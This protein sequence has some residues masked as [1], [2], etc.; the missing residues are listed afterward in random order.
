MAPLKTVSVPGTTDWCIQK[1]YERLAAMN[2]KA[3]LI[4]LQHFALVTHL[5]KCL[6]IRNNCLDHFVVQ[7]DEI[8]LNLDH[9]DFKGS[10]KYCNSFH[11]LYILNGGCEH[12][13]M[14]YKRIWE[15]YFSM[16]RGTIQC[17]L[18]L[19]SEFIEEY[20]CSSQLSCSSSPA[21]QYIHTEWWLVMCTCSSIE[22]SNGTTTS[23]LHEVFC[24]FLSTS[25]FK[26]KH[27]MHSPC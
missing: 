10:Y 24:T 17:E 3:G 20:C 25:L 6:G 11:C 27:F 13:C 8:L 12:H 16:E 23:R 14:G 1:C 2:S 5:W 22:M 21:V 4:L 7:L 19:I 18:F 9:T 26:D 15:A